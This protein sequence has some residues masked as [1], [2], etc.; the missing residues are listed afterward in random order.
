[1]IYG[2]NLLIAPTQFMFIIKDFGIG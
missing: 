2:M 1:L